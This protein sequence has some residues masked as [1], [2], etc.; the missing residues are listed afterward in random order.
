MRQG[1]TLPSAALEGNSHREEGTAQAW[2]PET[3]WGQPPE[4]LCSLQFAEAGKGALEDHEN[5]FSPH[6]S[7]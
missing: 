2:C 1:S 3:T 6:P 4:D 5:S 7:D